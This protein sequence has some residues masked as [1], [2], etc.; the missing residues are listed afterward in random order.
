MVKNALGERHCPSQITLG[1]NDPNFCILLNIGLYLESQF[2]SKVNDE[3]S[4]LNYLSFGGSSPTN[5]K[6][7]TSTV[8]REIFESD[9]FK[10][11]FGHVRGL[12]G[13]KLLEWLVGSHSVQK[14]APMHAH[15]NGSPRHLIN[16][17]GRWKQQKQQI[18]I[19]VDTTVLYPD[20]QVC[21]AL[22]VGGTIRYDLVIGSGFNN[23]RVLNNVVQNISQHQYC[24]KAAVVLCR[25]LG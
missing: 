18:D 14:L 4:I 10:A 21:S 15:H 16:I 13:Q 5:I 23:C 12:D 6:K 19:Y 7:K 24:K 2:P 11:A 3:G 17:C 22:Y 1:F 25:P 20:V 8:S 9:E